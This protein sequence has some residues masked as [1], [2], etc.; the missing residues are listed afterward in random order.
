MI[1]L[2]LIIA[3]LT[4]P[5]AAMDKP[6]ITFT[7]K[8]IPAEDV[9]PP[10]IYSN[11][12]G[13]TFIVQTGSWL[14]KIRPEGY[15]APE[16]RTAQCGREYALALRAKEELTRVLTDARSIEIVQTGTS[17]DRLLAIVTV[18]GVPLAH[19]MGE[20]GFT[21]VYHAS[22]GREPWCWQSWHRLPF[23]NPRRG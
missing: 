18:D 7:L 14:I 2:A 21:R 15:D 17:W 8:G 1:R 23:P 11:H 5:A 3:S 4:S 12:D 10:T 19:L 20:T 22:R 9:A 16:L 6:E 13:D